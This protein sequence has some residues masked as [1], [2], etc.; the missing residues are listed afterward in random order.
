MRLFN[1]F[2]TAAIL[3]MPVLAN[4]VWAEESHGVISVTGE[5]QVAAVPDMA[6]LTLGVTVN[7]DT[8]KAAL[9]ANSAALAAAIKRLKD[10]GIEDRDIQTSGLS[11][12]PIYD[13]S[14]SN[15]AP[16]TVLGYSASNMV[17]VRVRALETVGAVLDAA[18]TDGANTLN[19]ISFGLADPV[20]STDGARKAAVVDARHKAELYAAAAGVKV[21]KVVSINENGGYA[22][23]MMM[24]GLSEVTKDAVPVQAG[25]LSVG[26]SVTVTFELTE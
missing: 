12:G 8:A 23:P 5:G 13:Y 14:S 9:D 20:P 7:G 25:E 16:Q 4:P 15:G 6:T 26:A 10:A 17:T 22:P 18:V 21:G 1:M 24:G 2:A 19:G 11:L 3:A